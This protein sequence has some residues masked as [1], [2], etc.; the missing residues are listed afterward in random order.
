MK[1]TK[2][3]K[4]N[5]KIYEKKVQLANKL[6]DLQFAK[7]TTLKCTKCKKTIQVKKMLDCRAKWNAHMNKN[8][9]MG[10]SDSAFP[11]GVVQGMFVS[12]RP[13]V[14]CNTCQFDV[15][16]FMGKIPD[17]D[18]HKVFPQRYS[19]YSTPDEMMASLK[20]KKHPVY[21]IHYKNKKYKNSPKKFNELL[22]QSVKAYLK[23][24]P[25]VRYSVN[26]LLRIIKNYKLHDTLSVY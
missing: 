4:E 13:L 6:S 10:I 18:S 22:L 1:L 15:Y 11:F 8:R 25:H 20:S 5:N 19:T 16:R 7:V 9:K 26:Q 17:M 23:K 24:Y 3:Q 21:K 14:L 12:S 2:K